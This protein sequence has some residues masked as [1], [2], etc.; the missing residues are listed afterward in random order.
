MFAILR[1]ASR[2]LL[3]REMII[4]RGLDEMQLRVVAGERLDQGIT[5]VT[6]VSEYPRC[7]LVP[8]QC[9]AVCLSIAHV[10]SF[11]LVA[12]QRS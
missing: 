3:P 9:F 11:L 1:N 6:A 5:V 4:P 7:P 10:I 8:D 12:P 2:P